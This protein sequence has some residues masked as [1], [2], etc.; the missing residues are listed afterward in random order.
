MPPTDPTELPVGSAE[1]VTI[2]ARD[3]KNRTGI[4]LAA[5]GTYRFATTGQWIDLTVRCDA[6]GVDESQVAGLAR[7]TY[8][9]FG[10]TRRVREARWFELIGEVPAG[11]KRF[12]RIGAGMSGWVAPAGGMLVAFANDA[13]LM[14]WNN[15][16]SISLT[17]IREA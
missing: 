9:L 6:A 7:V 8:R 11:S 2:Q 14:Y 5:G 15:R 10:R 13:P 12:F 16:G 17:V 4:G 1:T 3:P